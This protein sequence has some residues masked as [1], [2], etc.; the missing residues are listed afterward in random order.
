M[1]R[2]SVTVNGLEVASGLPQPT[3]VSV[4]IHQE[5]V[6]AQLLKAGGALKEFLAL[7]PDRSLS[8]GRVRSGQLTLG[9]TQV[10]LGALSCILGGLL[11]AGPWTQLQ[12]TGCPFWAG[13]V[14]L[15][16]GAG[17]LVH[18]RRGCKCSG[19]AAGLLTLAALATALAAA[20]LCTLTFMAPDYVYIDFACDLG[21][22]REERCRNYLKMVTNM[23]RG[24]R[25][26]L[27]A[28]FLL[29]GIVSFASLG[30]SVRRACDRS[31]LPLEEESEKKLLGASS[32]PPS[33]SKEKTPLVL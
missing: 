32:A 21:S 30:L 10:V 29:Q 7:R 33:P 22:W 8:K 26:L 12:A 18:E 19:W 9:V 4:H 3:H 15:I 28:V 31:P 5:S 17:I 20:A 25:A 2:G 11:C 14:A 27:L 24:L 1:A 13:S 16:A 23:Y 6:L